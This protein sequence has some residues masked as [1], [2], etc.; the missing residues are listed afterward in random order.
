MSQ[1]APL[2]SVIVPTY[3]PGD[4]ID[5]VVR[6]LDA[7]TLP[8]DA[9]EVVLI[10]DGSPD[11]TLSRL[12]RL[13][14]TRPNY[15]VEQ[16]E[17]SG[18][19]SRPRNV[20]TRL[21][22][23][24][25]LLYMDHDDS[26]YPDALRRAYEFAAAA[27]LDLL[28]LKESKTK[29]G[30]WCMPALAAGNS[31][32]LK[33]NHQ[34]DRLLPMVPH[35]LYRRDFVLQADISFPEGRRMLWED[36]YFNVDAYAKAQRVGILADTPVYLWHSSTTNNSKSYGPRD[37]EFWDR[38]DDL[39]AFIDNALAAPELA[40]EHRSALMHQY[41]SRILR[42][43]GRALQ[44][45][46]RHQSALAVSRARAIQARY[47]PPEWDLLAR[48]WEYPRAIALRADRPDLLALLHRF[49]AGFSG[50]TRA[51][52]LRWID[53]A[54]T[55]D[56]AAGWFLAD[57]SPLPFQQRQDRLVLPL[58]DSLAEILD[59]PHVDVTDAL[60]QYILVIGARSRTDLVTWQLPLT[61]TLHRDLL[62]DGSVGLR[63]A[64]Q[65]AFDPAGV[66]FGRPAEPDVWDLLAVT[67]WAGLARAGG[68]KYNMPSSAALFSGRPAI[69]YKSNKGNLAVDLCQRLR[70]VVVDGGPSIGPV[71]DTDAGF[72]LALPRVTV[73]GT[74]LLSLSAILVDSAHPSH[75]TELPA[76][77]IGAEGSARLEVDGRPPSGTYRVLFSTPSGVVDS[78]WH[79]V[80]SGGELRIE[81]RPNDPSGRYWLEVRRGLAGIA[82]RTRK[83][84]A[85]LA[86]RADP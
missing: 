36:V 33:A 74:T 19:P 1:P 34:I 51:S 14:A 42:R 11:D 38:M 28:S 85:K 62:P 27:R 86:G 43:L 79:L 18:W 16:I 30:W 75:R 81:P 21:A 46:T 76:R 47:I 8:Q 53:G 40:A 20:A 68:L 56:V 10:D 23:G 48:P 58:P 22:R 60:A 61:Q 72:N 59:A 32:D 71:S 67:R 70:S 77:L 24:D 66:A 17:N 84:L 55:F 73:D 45:A 7:Q 13:A 63:I 41:R 35:K 4:G 44:G 6:S 29:D 83:A 39:M 82:A 31:I 37:V 3:Q 2:I 54:L 5:R 52:N 78:P 57:G 15:R 50:R 65:A 64:G 25:Y 26:L 80:S 12:S 69:A 49:Y 9:F